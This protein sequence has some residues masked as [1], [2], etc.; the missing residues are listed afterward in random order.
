MAPHE[1]LDCWHASYAMAI[2]VVKSTAAWPKHEMFGLSAQA[3][4]ASTSVPINIAEGAAKRGR[5]EFVRY[6]DIALGSLAEIE[7]ILRMAY[8]LGYLS[9][10]DVGELET[11]RKRAAKMVWKLYKVTQSG[12]GRPPLPPTL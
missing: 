12:A 2:A 1:E 7:V 3:R 5:R 10:S 6:L 9:S 11:R 4:R 8:D